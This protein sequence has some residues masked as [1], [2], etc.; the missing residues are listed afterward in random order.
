MTDMQVLKPGDRVLIALND[1]ATDEDGQNVLNELRCRFPDV[2]FT[3]IWGAREIVKPAEAT[4]AGS[5]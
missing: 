5:G 1:D 4:Q 2:E 3:A